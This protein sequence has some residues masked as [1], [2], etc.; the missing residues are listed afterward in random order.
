MNILK[1]TLKYFLICLIFYFLFKSLISNWGQI[2]KLEIK[3]NYSYVI[4]SLIAVMA[5]WV[6]SAWSWGRVLSAFN[7]KIPYRDVFIIYF[8]A[9]LGK[10]LPGKVWQIIGS[11]YYAAGHGVPEGIAITTSLIGQ[12]YSVLSGL[13]LFAMVGL[14]GR[15]GET[16]LFNT[17]FRW[18]LLPILA[19]LL[20]V[21]LKPDLAQPLLNRIMRL[22]KRQEVKI[23]LPIIRT[24]ELFTI[25]LLCWLLFGL[26]L[27]LFAKALTNVGFA[28]YINLTA[29]LAAAV[30]IG[31]LALFAPGGLGVREGV[32]ALFLATIPVFPPP[33][34]SAV[35]IGYRIIMT[36]AE[37]VAFGMTWVLKWT[38]KK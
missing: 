10:Y 1:N 9:N 32:I 5:A 12:A 17:I 11:A 22:F 3:L 8:K 24:I 25:Y 15:L 7:Y 26:G 27:W 13:S 29:V 36:I 21:A 4:Y 31:F 35:A 19:I 38:Q 34:P 18:S 6:V 20:A 28:Q 16:N 14:L 33:L 23:H 30:A 37:V 2:D